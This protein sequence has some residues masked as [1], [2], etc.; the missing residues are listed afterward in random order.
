MQ[1]QPS[2]AS[3]GDRPETDPIDFS[4]LAAIDSRGLGSQPFPGTGT[5]NTTVRARIP[6]IIA[7]AD[8]TALQS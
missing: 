8:V 3:R 1:E 2:Q 7:I 6:I 5:Q 4:L